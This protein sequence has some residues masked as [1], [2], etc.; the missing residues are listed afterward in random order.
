MKVPAINRIFLPQDLQI[1]EWSSLKPYFEALL[2]S[3]P[4]S[5]KELKE[6][7][8]K[9]SELEAVVSEDLAWRYIKMTCYTNDETLVQAYEYFVRE[10]QPHIAPLTDQLNKKALA[11]PYLN[12]LMQEEGF[13]IMIREMKK[14]VE[15]FREENIPLETE[16][17]SKA[18]K[19]GAISGLMEIEHNGQQLTLPQAAVL[20][21][22]T[23]R[24]IREQVYKKIGERRL[25]DQE[26]LDQ[27]FNELIDLR[28]K[29]ARNS[30][31]DNYRDYKFKAM[32]R[33][34]YSPED[35]FDFH[36]SVKSEVVP[37]LD[38]IAKAHQEKLG[39]STLKPWDTAVDP[40]GKAALQPFQ[41]AKDLTAKTIQ[42]FN[43]LDPFLGGCLKTMEEMGH[44]DLESRKAKSPGG[45]NYPLAET[46]VPFIFM[47]A[48]STLGDMVTL[49]HE[50]GHAVHS[51]L[52]NELELA[53]FKETPS[54]V[55]ELASMSM[56][57]I[58]MD[59]WDV[60][61][62]NEEDLTRAKREHLEQII[63][64]LPWVATIDKF[65]HWIY[66]HPNHSIEE[67]KEEW[68]KLFADFSDII[69]DWEGLEHIKDYI[70]QKQLHL[71]EVPFYYIEYGMAQL[72][73]IAIWKNFRENPQEGL[74]SY[75][76][77]LKL[78]Y[79][80]SIPEIYEAAHIKFDFSKENI[81][82]LINFVADELK[83]L[84]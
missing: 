82:S 41:G 65:Q 12:E 5:S 4:E 29:V 59:H 76:K 71:F 24:E 10:I 50:G 74:A 26:Q 55:A 67:R 64:T 78:G 22:S 75:M 48:T 27:L 11:S 54:E 15:I 44:L 42:C 7:F 68:N 69:T 31:F 2:A 53:D 77:A 6:W 56:E 16:I 43:R 70:W 32:G 28:T 1:K 8:K 83:K 19:Y 66:E 30:G 21:K 9:R 14:E 39:L 17:S 38:G 61:F 49:L 73:A 23:D 81:S 62:E 47:N 35:C 80:A 45:Y 72:G 36:H 20:L 3:E 51:F 25:Q 79:T 18:Q 33:F 84:G 52:M 60:F 46:G 57:L 13:D 63:E 37:L 58:T 34:D 40:S